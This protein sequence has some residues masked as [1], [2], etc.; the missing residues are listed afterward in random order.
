MPHLFEEFTIRGVTLRN[1]IG[2]SPMCQYWSQ[3]GMASDWHLVH[4]GSRA[5]GGAGL[6]ICEATAVEARGRITPGDAGIWSD[7]H[8]EP[9]ARINRFI[10]E[11]GAVT[12]IQLAHAGRKASTAPPFATDGD[13]DRSLSDKQGGW[14][15]VG[16]S[17]IPFRKDSRVPKELT[18]EQIKEVQEA[19]RVATIRSRTA[20]YQ[21]VEL[22]A[23]HGYLAHSF[24]SPLSN[25][26]QDEY[27]G[28]FENRTRFTLETVRL[29]REEWPEEY[30]FSVRLSCTDWFEDGWTLEESIEL[31]KQLKPLGVDVI[32]CSSGFGAPGGRYPMGP[33]W[34]VPFAEAIRKEAN[35]PTA[36][37]GAIADP[38]Q[39]EQIIRNGQADIVLLATEI[40]R[41]P[42]W[43]FHAA[44]T[45][46]PKQTVFNLPSPYDY[47]LQG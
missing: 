24:H 46:H 12:G 45:L 26:R 8:I 25:Q 43:P 2:V 6:V 1:R 31:S 9:L 11:Y 3:D 23:A 35:I 7:E 15:I 40:L 42:Y 13:H 34:Q 28:S 14:E 47:V 21:W 29:M 33:G 4:L 44:R 39:A 37:V 18:H 20:G 27:G 16:P 41:D 17:P 38:R 36:A 5:V 19:F 32:D 22:H 30:P 10:K